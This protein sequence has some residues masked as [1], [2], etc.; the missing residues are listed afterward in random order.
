MYNPDA[1][2]ADLYLR[3]RNGN[4]NSQIDITL[5]ITPQYKKY[6]AS[7]FTSLP[8][9]EVKVVSQVALT[10]GTFSEDDITYNGATATTTA[11]MQVANADNSI[12]T[13]YDP[14]S[15]SNF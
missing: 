13:P 8:N 14:N 6:G 3:M 1:G 7:T 10:L 15:S 12:V 9:K 2:S 11:T 5:Q 4:T